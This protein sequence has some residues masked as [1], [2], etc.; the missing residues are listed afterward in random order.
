VTFNSQLGQENMVFVIW[1]V[2]LLDEIENLALV[3]L[4]WVTLQVVVFLRWLPHNK[5]RNKHN[6][7][8]VLKPI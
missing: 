5:Q 7:D 3:L 2:L 8:V 4:L 6:Q 1:P